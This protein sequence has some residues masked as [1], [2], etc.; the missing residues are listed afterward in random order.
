LDLADA[1]VSRA[2]KASKRAGPRASKT[3]KRAGPRASK[4]RMRMSNIA[5]KAYA[6]TLATPIRRFL[7][8]VNKLI[9]WAVGTPLLKFS[10]RGLLTLSMIHYAR[11]V[12][13]RDRDFPRLSPKQPREKLR[14]AY[15]FFCS[16]FNGSW[17]QYVDSFAAVIPTGL[18]LLWFENV[19]W[20]NAIPE[21]PFHRYVEFN[22]IWTDYYYSAY[23]MAASNDVKSA[24]KVKEKLCALAKSNVDATPEAFLKQYNLMLKELQGDL[25]QLAES[26]IVSLAAEEIAARRRGI[27]VTTLRDIS[28]TASDAPPPSHAE[29]I[30]ALAAQVFTREPSNDAARTVVEARGSARE[31]NEARGSAREQ[32]EARGSTREQKRETHNAE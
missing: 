3:S 7:A 18:N 4:T 17:E 28:G 19:G 15:M 16:N 9:F 26:P 1:A 8:P 32:N 6:M 14:Y 5:G 2:S 22:Q 29:P 13:L 25:S 11:W 21:Q 20:P 30:S 31:Q 23:P 24:Q 12:I 10:L 27:R